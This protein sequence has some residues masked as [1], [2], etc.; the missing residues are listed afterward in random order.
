MCAHEP[1]CPSAKSPARDLACVIAEH[2]EQ[3]WA[4]LCNG[5]IHFD[6]GIDLL[7]SGATAGPRCDQLAAVR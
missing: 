6:D 1:I 3:G 2:H 5:V 4:L 7:P